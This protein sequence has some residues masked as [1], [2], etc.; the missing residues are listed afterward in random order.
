VRVWNVATG[1]TVRRYELGGSINDLELSRDGRFAVA[2]SS[3]GLA[4][5]YGVAGR[6]EVLLRG[7]ADEVVAAVFSPDG[8]RVASASADSTARIWNART[9]R[10]VVLAG[11]SGALTALAF[12]NDGTLL[13]TAGADADIRVWN[14]RSGAEVTVLRIHSGAVND[15]T[16]SADG[17]WIASAGPLS[18]GIWQVG[19]RGVWSSSPLYLVDGDAART[20]R[21]DH[22]AFSPKGWRLLTGWRLGNVRLFDC[23]LC[24]GVK[25]LSV[26]A[27]SRLTQ[28][29]RRSPSS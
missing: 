16:F 19:K 1:T 21:L 26:I 11:H 25:E 9:G 4:A 2:A 13:A 8:T 6:S 10:S 22:L 27:K 23:A 17:R 5:V 29:V 12:N 7:H 3:S 20:P 14:G 24:G 18:A 28:I 15:V